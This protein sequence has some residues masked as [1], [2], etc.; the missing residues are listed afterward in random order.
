MDAIL[1]PDIVKDFQSFIKIAKHDS[2]AE[3]ECKLLSGKI[4]TKDVADRILQAIATLSIGIATEEH[5]LTIAYPDSTRVVVKDPLNIQKLCVT[6]SFREIPLLVEKKQRYYDSNSSKKDVIDASE[7]NMRFTLRTEESVRKDW[8]GNPSDPKG[9]IRLINRRSY[10]TTNNL[11]RID[12]SMVKTRPSNSK[13]SLK[14]LLKQQH[15]YELEIEFVNKQTKFTDEEIA[16][17]LLHIASVLSQGYYRSPFL[18]KMSDI[19]RY[20]HEFKASNHVFFNPITMV[21]RHLNPDNPHNISKGYTVTN[22]ADGV[23]SALFVAKDRR[24]LRI[25]PTLQ[26]VWTGYTAMYDT[27]AGDFIDGE[28]ISEKNMFCIFDIYR[29]RNKD[30]RNLPLLKTDEDVLQNPLHSRLGCAKLFV[31]DLK[32]QFVV[33][34]SEIPLQ[35]ETKLFLAGDGVSMEESIKTI[36]QTDFGYETDGLIFTPR[37]SS[38]APFE[39]RRGRTWNK[40]YKWKPASQ[41]TIDFLIKVL[42][43]DTYDPIQSKKVRKGELYISRT[44]N[45]DIIY[46]RETMTGEYVAPKLP[47]DLQRVADTNSRIPAIFQPIVPRDPD[48]YQ[49][50]IPL[51]DQ[52]IPI[53]KQGNRVEDNTIIECA[54]DVETRRWS[55]LR[56]RYDKTYQYRVLN[57]PQYGNDISVANS[58]WTSIHVPV[59]EEMLSTFISNPPHGT[60]EDDLYYKDDLKRTSRIFNDVYS[61]HNRVKD[62]LYKQN[63]KKGDTLLELAVGRGGD[64]HKWKRCHPSKIVGID[65]SLSNLISPVQGAATRYL[66][67]KRKNPYDHLPPTLFV[68][69]DMTE[70]PL[71]GQGD[72][73]M[74]ILTGQAKGQTS[75]LEQFEGLN[76]FDTISCEFAIHYACASEEIFRNFA[77][78]LEKYGKDIFF[79][80]CLDGQSVYSLLLNKRSY[81]FGC[82]KQVCGEY[83]KQYDDKETW[84]EE[85]GMPI[86]VLMESWENHELE[87]LVPFEK[88]TEILGEVGYKLVESKMFKD[89]YSSQTDIVLGQEQQTFTFL[90]RTF[91]FKKTKEHVEEKIEE[92]KINEAPNYLEKEDPPEEPKK[93][94]LK[95][96]EEAE[97]EPVLF[98]GSDE[99]KGEYRKFSNMSEHP[100]EVD[101]EKFP[102]VEHYFQG[103]KAKEFGDTE[104]Y[105]KIVKAK[106]PKAVKA[107]GKKVKNFNKDVW[108]LKRES[109]MEAGLKAKFTQHPELR[110]QLM[111]TGEKIIGEAD[112]R[113][114]FWGIG[115]AMGTPKSLKPSKWRGQNKMGK[116][117]MEL[118][119][120]FT[121]ESE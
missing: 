23:R 21:R 37:N 86:K 115:S 63:V 72:K 101:G 47:P 32:K 73:Y 95:K 18:L 9:Y 99:S 109:I 69:G 106:T 82:D 78:N 67:D 97:E 100:I 76:K 84:V 51:S 94:K 30:I 65:I 113:N 24:L 36:L 40:V 120:K 19:Q 98:F 111:E 119:Q 118:R 50:L 58:N 110:K 75:Y 33:S 103:M 59:T 3:L 4:Q 107:L 91:V 55:I 54:F 2:K 71:F 105:D 42:P 114:T 44:P 92:T 81:L 27:H 25:D 68:E 34:P 117:L 26:L 64:L 6:N 22:K 88:V 96:T 53:D 46:P 121:G 8:E 15:T 17:D 116:L 62:E 83:T 90:N 16:K 29:F 87:Y 10:K 52:N 39:D 102:T 7:G 45:N 93:T 11:F 60:Y 89:I 13:K 14:D 49:I 31:Q 80:T 74:P 85:F 61:F 104:M 5:R 56:T 41:N 57:D 108:E 79:G 66:T 38:V 112:A 20:Q 12:F 48:A 70:F 35:V 43:D 28:Y 1:S 77:K